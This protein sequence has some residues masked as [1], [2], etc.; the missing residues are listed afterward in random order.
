MHNFFCFNTVFRFS[1][2]IQIVTVSGLV[3]WKR[4]WQLTFQRNENRACISF[5]SVLIASASIPAFPVK[6]YIAVTQAWWWCMCCS[7]GQLLYMAPLLCC[8]WGMSTNK[9]SSDKQGVEDLFLVF[10]TETGRILFTVWKFK[11]IW[12]TPFWTCFLAFLFY[13]NSVWS[14]SMQIFQQ[15]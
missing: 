14:L 10:A 12:K 2:F 1:L 11:I 15:N 4:W 3:L 5:Y 6:L 13:W 9:V 8:L 7:Q